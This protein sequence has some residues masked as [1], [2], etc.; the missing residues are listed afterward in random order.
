MQI[1]CFRHGKAVPVTEG[2]KDID[3]VLGEIG[4]NQALDRRA[5]MGDPRFDLVISSPAPRALDTAAIVSGGNED[6]FVVVPDLYPD[7]SKEVGKQIDNAFARLA[8]V[9]VAQYL[10]DPEGKAIMTWAHN[11]WYEDIKGRLG[12][13]ECVAIFG[14]AVCLQALGIQICED[15]GYAAAQIIQLGNLNLGECEGFVINFD[16]NGMVDGIG[17]INN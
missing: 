8:Y 3:R 6:T 12:N 4:K 2:G 7:P 9:P 1:F 13:A 11:V 16:D 17:L 15:H 10:E 14:H 5:K